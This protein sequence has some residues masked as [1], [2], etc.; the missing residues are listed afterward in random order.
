MKMGL[1][2]LTT[3]AVFCAG[4]GV[5]HAQ[6]QDPVATVT[7]PAGS[8]QVVLV[9]LPTDIRL[10]RPGESFEVSVDDIIST[11]ADGRA[12]V[13]YQADGCEVPM[14]SNQSLHVS[15][16]DTEVPCPKRDTIVACGWAPGTTDSVAANAL[17]SGDGAAA[18]I[19]P[20]NGG[21]GAAVAATSGGGAPIA[22]GALPLLGAEALIAGGIAGGGVIGIAALSDDNDNGSSVTVD[23]PDASPDTF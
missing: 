4:L 2:K 20:L 3:L 12:T 22:G 5:A 10:V 23:P 17:G 7:N 6:A 13:T 11:L 19:L 8:N 16:S 14:G 9:Y 15:E 1:S 21:E 18:G